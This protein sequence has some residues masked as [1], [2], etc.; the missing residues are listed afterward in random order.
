MREFIRIGVDL[1]KG[2]FQIHALEH[3]GSPALKRKLS[4][5]RFL[6]FFVGLAPCRI[7]MEACGSA[8]YWARELRAM[9]H[10]VVLMGPIYVKPYLKRGKNDAN[11]AA[12]VLTRRCLG[13]G[14]GSFRSRAPTSKPL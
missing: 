8:H 14:C 1:S 6:D 7:G 3:E 10:E 5:A 13:P 4:R 12:A 9:G 11:D 2:F